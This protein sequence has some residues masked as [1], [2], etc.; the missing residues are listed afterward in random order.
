VL[1]IAEKGGNIYVS[2][3]FNFLV[4]IYGFPNLWE[5]RYFQYINKT[6]HRNR[7]VDIRFNMQK[8]QQRCETFVVHS[9][10]GNVH[11]FISQS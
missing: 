1:P 10:G 8:V 4:K 7:D 5:E 2:K 11:Q 3:E 6:T 9:L